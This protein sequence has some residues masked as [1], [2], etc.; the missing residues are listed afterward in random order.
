MSLIRY[1]FK[2]KKPRKKLVFE[3]L[4]TERRDRDS[5]HYAFTVKISRFLRYSAHFVSKRFTKIYR[6][7]F[8]KIFRQ[9]ASLIYRLFYR[10]EP[11]M[12]PL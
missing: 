2:T 8:A 4:Y 3:V 7:V 12:S 6:Q 1:V 9:I 11:I 5:P 10:N